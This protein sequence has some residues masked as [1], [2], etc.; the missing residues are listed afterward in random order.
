MILLRKIL[1]RTHKVVKIFQ[2]RRELSSIYDEANLASKSL[3]NVLRDTLDGRISSEEKFWIDKIESLR[4][5]LN[6]S[7]KEISIVDYGAGSPDLNLTEEEMYQ[8][9]VVTRSIGD[10]YRTGSKSFFWA[11]LL[12][13]LL[14][15]FRPSVCLELGTSLG[16]SASYQAA[17]LKLNQE[18]YIVTLEGA[19]SLS[20]LAEQHFRTLGFDNV[21]VIVGRFQDT[22]GKVLEEHGPID[23]AFIDGHHSEKATLAYFEQVLSYASERA[24]LVFDDISWSEGM[25]KAWSTIEADKR[26]KITVDLS[27]VGICLINSSIET[28][29]CFSIPEFYAIGL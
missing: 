24:V 10:V 3:V 1:K 29:R 4:N 15:D 23:Y 6:S 28:K 5:E 9:R 19:E 22:L 14:R 18:G 12:F 20:S 13:R 16:I 2:A 7:N 26:V 8:G 21:I 27:T 17:A 11:F 25:E